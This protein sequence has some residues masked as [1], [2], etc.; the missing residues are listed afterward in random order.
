MTNIFTW[1]KCYGAMVGI[2]ASRYPQK[3]VELMAYQSTIIKCRT[4]FEGIAWVTYDRAYR[5]QAAVLKTLDWSK[6]NPTLYSLCL[7]GRAKSDIACSFC[8]SQEHKSIDCP[9][10]QSSNS[11][12]YD[13]KHNRS[14][15]PHYSSASNGSVE[16]C[17]LFNAK[18]GS[19]CR[20]KPYKYA[21]LCTYC[22]KKHTRL[23][24]AILWSQSQKGQKQ[25]DGYQTKTLQKLFYMYT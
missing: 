11:S 25:T 21:H 24:L 1:L 6:L 20:F 16:I 7:A 19:K 22:K 13:R 10:T 5:T 8:R 9:E 23:Q 15:R 17:R 18:G 12:Y 2:L 14:N 4:D 3:V